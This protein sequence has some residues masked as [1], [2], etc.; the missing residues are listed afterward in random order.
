MEE[1]DPYHYV[2]LLNFISEG[3]NK[4]EEECDWEASFSKSAAP[5]KHSRLQVFQDLTESEYHST[6]SCSDRDEFY[7]AKEEAY[8]HLS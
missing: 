7:D 8:D 5:K 2:H 6:Q 1:L 4:C 3:D